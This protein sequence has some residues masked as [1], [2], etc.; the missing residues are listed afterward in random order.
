MRTLATAALR[1]T[2]AHIRGVTPVRRRA[3]AG[4][5]ARVYA[6]VER[7]FGLLAPPVTLHSPAPG[8]LAA[9]WLMLRES[10]VATGA[11]ERAAKE[12]V[13]TAVSLS[14]ACPY[15]VEVHGATLHGLLSGA[16][17]TA[18]VD[19]RLESIADP[20]V[21]R[22]AEWA[23]ASGTRERA[24]TP[25]VAFPADQLPELIGVAVTFHYINR[26]VNVFLT[27]SP[28]PPGLPAGARNRVL[29]VFA[30][31]MRMLAGQARQPGA[32]LDLLPAAPLPA[33]LGWA[34][35]T[36][37][38]AGAF[39]RA[40]Q[41]IELGGS[42]SVPEP[43]RELVTAEL[44]GWDGQPPGLDGSWVADAVAGLAPA[45]RPAGRLALLTAMASYR[46]H[47]GL[48]DEFRLGVSG[49]LGRPGDLGRP[50][51]EALVELTAWASFAAARQVGS[52]LWAGVSRAVAGADRSE[53]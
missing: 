39:A 18:I 7:D 29:R 27:E 43:V 17:V 38:V 23:R 53:E 6:Q 36:P 11:A 10:L 32:S 15:C 12:A 22:L 49:H 19:G 48:V 2:Q 47:Q 40:A 34:A 16:D 25:G 35:G 45:D 4:L 20:Q 1:R 30:R 9:S 44:A 14:N 28:L 46:V 42:R 51:D 33:D 26:M 5:V 8:A 31:V 13:A 41:A 24:A 21:R 52:W 37:A 3:A 50:A